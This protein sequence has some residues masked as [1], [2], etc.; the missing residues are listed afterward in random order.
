MALSRGYLPLSSYDF[1][2]DDADEI[3]PDEKPTR[4]TTETTITTTSQNDYEVIESFSITGYDDV[5][6]EM[7][8][9]QVRMVTST[10]ERWKVEFPIVLNGL[11][12]SRDY[13]RTITKVNELTDKVTKK[14]C[15]SNGFTLTMLVTGSLIFLP[16]IPGIALMIRRVKK[17]NR[18]IVNYFNE[19]NRDC[20]SR[21]YRWVLE[22]VLGGVVGNIYIQFFDDSKITHQQRLLLV[23]HE[24][25]HQQQTGT[26]AF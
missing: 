18:G 23:A 20:S 25:G 15:Y 10:V 11:V 19:I 22:E 9:Y 17:I 5:P 8:K 1:S 2:S 3:D 12:D 13:F 21:G 16:L 6:R 7:L 4:S 24:G 26:A 14:W